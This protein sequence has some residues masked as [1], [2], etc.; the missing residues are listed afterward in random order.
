MDTLSF[1]RLGAVVT[2]VDFSSHAVERARE[3]ADEA[4]LEARFIQANVYDL[5]QMLDEQFDVVYTS[6]GVLTWLPD[7]AEWGR[8]V[9][10]FVK[11]GGQFFIIEGHPIAWIFDQSNPD[12]FAFDFGYFGQGQTHTFSD[13][14]TYADM[15]AVLE[16]VTSHEWHHRLD[17][18]LNALIDAGLQIQH[19]GEYPFIAWQMLPFMEKDERGWWRIPPDKPQVPLMFSIEATK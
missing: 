13:Q 9:A 17:Q 2:G 3:L 14:G 4:G 15:G 7:I 5:P 18:I 16:N 6:H 11:P 12:G 19:V 10:T 1:A 8:V